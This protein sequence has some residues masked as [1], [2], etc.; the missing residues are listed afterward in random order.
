MANEGR[1]MIATYLQQIEFL[2]PWILLLIMLVPF[3]HWYSRRQLAKQQSAVAITSTKAL[4][5]IKT[6][7]HK[8]MPLPQWLRS[9]AIVCLLVALA[10]PVQ[11][12]N[13]EQTNGE[14]IEIVLCLDISGSML[15]RDFEPDRLRASIDMAAN[16]VSGRNGDRI[17]LVAF[18]GQSL[19]LCP[20][21]SDLKAV[22][23]QLY[24]IDYGM[25]SDGTSIGSGL[26][27]AVAKLRG[28]IARSR[29]IILLTDGEDTGGLI[30]PETALG[31]AKD[32]GYKV[33]TIGVGKEGYAPM[34]YKNQAGQIEMQEE[35]VSKDE[36]L[37]KKIA[38]N[39][40][41]KYFRATSTTVL[42]EIYA[43][44]DGLEK[45]KIRTD[46]YRKQEER[47]FPWAFAA[48]ALVATEG[49][50]RTVIMK[51]LL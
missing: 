18:A 12:S 8:L 45:S 29:I 11:F 21:T 22:T 6:W 35:K 51:R 1:K 14:G 26:A 27:S 46:I 7:R 37:L 25:L 23:T 38:E 36:A 9:L 34:P 32:Y 3:W 42:K 30:D 33:Y 24:S 48:L 41:G 5:G 28:G 19:S 15:A 10:R 31:F 4:P 49:I 39:T 43:A 20:L 40:G 50:W 16:F 47:F 13:I 2:H 44:I 17:A